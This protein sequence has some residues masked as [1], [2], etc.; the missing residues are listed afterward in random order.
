MDW[1]RNEKKFSAG[2]NG[3]LLFPR[4]NPMLLTFLL[5]FFNIND[6]E[7]IVTEDSGHDR[8]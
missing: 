5:L 6:S 3:R 2:Q 4:T 7:A 8:K 1:K